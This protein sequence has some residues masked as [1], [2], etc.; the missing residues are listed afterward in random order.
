MGE[1]RELLLNLAE[2]AM[3]ARGYGGFSYA[4]I[5]RDAGI[6]KASIHHHFPSKQDMGLAVLDRY[7][8]RLV[9]RLKLIGQ[10]SRSGGQALAA[11]IDLYRERAGSGGMLCLCAAMSGDVHAIDDRIRSALQ[12]IND[13]VIASLEEILVTGRGDRSISVGGDP[14]AEATSILAM[15][16]GAQ[17]MARVT[18]NPATFDAATEVLAARIYRG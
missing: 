7:G 13:L 10:S 3:C 2:Q 5:A 15:L 11:I 16:Q 6:R 1:M 8:E 17:L 12:R 18:M 9:Q 4:D 14:K